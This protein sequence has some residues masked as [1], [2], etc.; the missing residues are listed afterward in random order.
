MYTLKRTVSGLN[1]IKNGNYLYKNFIKQRMEICPWPR[2]ATPIRHHPD[3]SSKPTQVP[4]KNIS[5]G[6]VQSR[7]NTQHNNTITIFH[8]LAINHQRS[9]VRLVQIP[10][11]LGDN[12]KN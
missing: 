4:P 8:V 1:N 3:L 12:K 2:G 7:G 5:R 9:Y 6:G 11:I 10:K